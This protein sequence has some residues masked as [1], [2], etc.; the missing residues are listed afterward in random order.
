M[1]FQ[2]LETRSWQKMSK[3][4]TSLISRAIKYDN[5]YFDTCFINFWKK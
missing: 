5:I 2:E 4:S 3:P 1:I